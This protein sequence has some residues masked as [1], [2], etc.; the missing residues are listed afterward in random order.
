MK[1]TQDAEDAMNPRC[2]TLLKIVFV[3]IR[4]TAN[5]VNASAKY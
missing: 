3:S 2:S 5:M 1:W 4:Q